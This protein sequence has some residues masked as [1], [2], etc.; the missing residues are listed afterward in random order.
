MSKLSIWN[1]PAR[2]CVDNLQFQLLYDLILR[3]SPFFVTRKD[4]TRGPFF[5]ALLNKLHGQNSWTVTACLLLMKH[6]LKLMCWG[7]FLEY[8]QRVD[9]IHS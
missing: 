3:G 1:E 2:R 4:K 5:E 7:K 9:A 8:A 6:I